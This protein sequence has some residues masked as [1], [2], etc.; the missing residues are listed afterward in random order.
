MDAVLVRV[1]QMVELEAEK[2]KCKDVRTRNISCHMIN[3]GEL[4]LKA[5]AH[6][7][8]CVQI[9]MDVDVLVNRLRCSSPI[10]EYLALRSECWLLIQSV[11]CSGVGDGSSPWV[12]LLPCG[13]VG[14][15]SHCHL[16]PWATPFIMDIWGAD[17]WAE[18]LSLCLSLSLCILCCWIK[19][20]CNKPVKRGRDRNK[21]RHSEEKYAKYYL[22]HHKASPAMA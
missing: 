6:V 1:W 4:K 7:R 10:S 5:D 14:M 3:G 15:S 2:V 11:S 22:S 8:N 13:S 21:E 20:S 12:P 18:I 16:Y 19:I 17:E 9:E